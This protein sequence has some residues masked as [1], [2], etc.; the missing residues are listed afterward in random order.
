MFINIPLFRG[1]GNYSKHGD[2][3]LNVALKLV[4]KVCNFVKFI[5]NLFD[6]FFLYNRTPIECRKWWEEYFKVER[7]SLGLRRMELF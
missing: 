2:S 6:N 3:E 7:Q 4:L 5:F 1:K